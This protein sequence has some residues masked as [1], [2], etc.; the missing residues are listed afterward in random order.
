MEATDK[1]TPCDCWWWWCFFPGIGWIFVLPFGLCSPT[2][3]TLTKKGLQEI[4]V[5]LGEK[6]IRCEL[7]NLDAC[8]CK[9]RTWAF[10]PLEHSA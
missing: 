10:I 3:S 2:A 6:M 7:H 1:P 4:R 8:C 9:H 5:L